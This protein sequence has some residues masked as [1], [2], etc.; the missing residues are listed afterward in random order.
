MSVCLSEAQGV[1]TTLFRS[2]ISVLKPTSSSSSTSPQISS[3]QVDPADKLSP[4]GSCFA[5]II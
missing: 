2:L 4:S 5:Q 3:P 1:G